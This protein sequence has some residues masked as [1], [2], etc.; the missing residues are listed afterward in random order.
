MFPGHEPTFIETLYINDM[1]DFLPPGS[2]RRK[3]L[4]IVSA[5]SYRTLYQDYTQVNCNS[6]P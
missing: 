3:S 6:S 5:P 2:G 1:P 4:G